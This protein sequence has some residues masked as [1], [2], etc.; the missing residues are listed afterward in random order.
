MV[1]RFIMN[2]LFMFLLSSS[3]TTDSQ[4]AFLET[5]NHGIILVNEQLYNVIVTVL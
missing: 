2:M 4:I 5:N 3:L 1:L